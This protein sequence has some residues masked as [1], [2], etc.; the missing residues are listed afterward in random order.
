MAPFVKEVAEY[1]TKLYVGEEYELGSDCVL[2]KAAPTDATL[3]DYLRGRSFFRKD[4]DL[5]ENF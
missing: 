4:C 5:T 1:V 2:R 3:K